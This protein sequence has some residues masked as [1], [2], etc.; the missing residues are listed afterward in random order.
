MLQSMG[1]QIV[2]HN[3]ATEQQQGYDMLVQRG[4]GT[5]PFFA[6]GGLAGLHQETPG[7]SL[8]RLCF[9]AK[10]GPL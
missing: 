6:Q 7:L 5:S 2:R 3:V 4:R 8:A 10:A 9:L 1:M